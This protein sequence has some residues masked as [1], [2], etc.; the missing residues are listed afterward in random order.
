[1]PVPC[2]ALPAV[3]RPRP[4]EGATRGRESACVNLQDFLPWLQYSSIYTPVSRLASGVPVYQ[5]SP[6]LAKIT[7]LILVYWTRFFE[8]ASRA[9]LV[10]N[11]V[12]SRV[13]H[14]KGK[15]AGIPSQYNFL[16]F[17]RCGESVSRRGRKGGGK[18]DFEGAHGLA[19][20][21]KSCL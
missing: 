13:S 17:C 3:D 2:R 14:T 7:A 20:D 16:Q 8:T 10:G 11:S 6:P 5:K 15:E 4:F 18:G 9:I 12:A 21:N 19:L 1:M